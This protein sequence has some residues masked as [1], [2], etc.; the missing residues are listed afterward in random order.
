MKTINKKRNSMPLIVAIPFLM[1]LGVDMYVPS[2]PYVANYFHTTATFVEWSVGLYMLGYGSGQVLF[3]P[4]SDQIGRKK[5]M[6]ISS[7]T[8][9][10]ISI[11]IIFSPNISTLNILRCFQGFTIAGLAVSIRAVLADVFTEIELKKATT[12]FS[13]SWSIGPIVG[14]L[15]GAHLQELFGW[16]SN[17]YLFAIYSFIV[18]IY[19][20]KMFSETCELNEKSDIHSIKADMQEVI[21][22]KNFV[23]IVLVTAI[24]YAVTIIFNTVGPFIVEKV[25]GKSIDYF[26]DIAMV[27]GTAYLIGVTIN[28]LLVGKIATKKLI[29]MGLFVDLLCGILMIILNLFVENVFTLI[30]PVYLIFLFIGFITPNATAMAMGIFKKNKGIASSIFGVINGLLVFVLSNS[31]SFLNIKGAIALAIIYIALIIISIL[32]IY[33]AR[34]EF[35]AWK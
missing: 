26:G 24:M 19:V 14:P 7:F 18:F 30:A 22:H 12:Y 21:K 11:F 33:G 3:G 13:I 20:L 16:K 31:I 25:M 2:L 9:L 29:F 28:R 17:F 10:L 4:L 34:K 35:I 8:F 27:L 1:G 5:V 6:L 15:I 23:F 32:L